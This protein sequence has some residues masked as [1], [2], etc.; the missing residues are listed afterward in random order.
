MIKPGKDWICEKYP[1]NENGK[2][3][4]LQNDSDGKGSYIAYWNVKDAQGKL[5][6]KMSHQEYLDLKSNWSSRMKEW[7]AYIGGQK[8]SAISKLKTMGL[9]DDEIESLHL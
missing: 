9:T 3:Y 7:K 6:P 5:I 8:V 1:N 2:D 4:I